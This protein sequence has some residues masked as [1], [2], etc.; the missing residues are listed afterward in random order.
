MPEVKF[1]PE[2]IAQKIV[3]TADIGE[4]AKREGCDVKAKYGR[5]H[6]TCPNCGGKQ[7]VTIYPPKNGKPANF[8]CHK[9]Q[10]FK[11]VGAAK[12]LMLAKGLTYPEALHDLAAHYNIDIETET[13]D[14]VYKNAPKNPFRDKQ[15]LASGIPLEVQKWQHQVKETTW[16]ERDRYEGGSLQKDQVVPGDDMILNYITLEGKPM[17]FKNKKGRMRPLVRVRWQHPHLHL[18]KAGKPM[19]YKSLY[20]SPSAVWLP[21][22]LIAAWIKSQQFD[23]LY[24]PEGEKKSEK[25]TIHGMYAAGLQGINNLNFGE[26]TTTFERIITRC[27]VKRI[28]FVVDSDWDNISSGENVDWRPKQF[29]TAAKK[30]KNYFYGYRNSFR[31]DG[32]SI[33]LD[34]YIA[35][36]LDKAEKG[37]DD[38]LSRSLK[39]REEELEQDY[40]KAFIDRE[41]VGKH[42]RVINITTI[43]EYKLQELWHL[44]S[45]AKFIEEHKDAL[46]D[47][48]QF[49]INGYAYHW[50]D[51]EAELMDQIHEDEQFWHEEPIVDRFGEPK[52]DGDGKEKFKLSFNYYACW[53]FLRNRG[54]YLFK[55][56]E[57]T[58]G[59]KYR[60]IRTQGKVVTETDPHEIQQFV[61]NYVEQLGRIDVL[62]MLFRGG[63]QYLGPDKLGNLWYS[64]PDFIKPDPD[65]TY[66]V[67]KNNYWKI[68][69][70]K[71][72]QRPLNEMSRYVW[73]RS[74]IDF[75]PKLINDFLSVEREGEDWKVTE[76]EAAKQCEMY[77]FYLCTSDFFWRKKYEL[78][79]DDEGVKFWAEKENPEKY[80][81]EEIAEM[82][83]HMVCKMIA[84]GYTLQGYRKKSM[85][86]A[87]VAMD[88][89]ETAVGKSE[90]GTGKSI[91]GTQFG[92]RAGKI[93]PT[94][95][96]D[97]KKDI[98]RDP[99]PFDGLDERHKAIVFDDVR[100]NFKFEW[101]FSK[102]TTGIEANWKNRQKLFLDPVPIWIITNHAIR[103]NSNSYLRRQYMLAFSDFFNGL[104]SPYDVFGHQLF[105]DW[106]WEEWNRYYNFIACC[107]QTYLRFNN[108]NRYVI[109]DQ[110]LE[111]RKLRQEIGENFLEFA[112]L[113][114]D[115]PDDTSASQVF[116]PEALQAHQG[117]YRNVAV[118][119]KKVYKDF[120]TECPQEQRFTSV[121]KVK[122]KVKLYCEYAGL[123]F[124]PGAD[125][126]G[127]I[128]SGN[129][130]YL[131]VADE[132]FN[133]EEMMR[134]S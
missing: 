82:T 66:L 7:K 100:V 112:E 114:F 71:I 37:I 3:D 103:G 8:K 107:I 74:I 26:M 113:Y 63:S 57:N 91:L 25:M 125:G 54:Y 56:K 121:M 111:K 84:T 35:F 129:L 12:F 5:D 55:I 62:N 34:I 60:L 118:E 80:T 83:G 20:G 50:V 75:E 109:P 79:T 46:K 40:Q 31:E 17:M 110:D 99:F 48:K 27:G 22:L 94:F 73:E 45:P 19:K 106:G 1:I 16:M 68:T 116:G 85:M 9:C 29:F 24:I 21:Q 119:K 39:G 11:G 90:G 59:N 117:P 122:Y 70:D 61:K 38:V 105:D 4:I 53:Q 127:R 97:G 72:E 96:I 44:Q 13:V 77:L 87:I 98:D 130:E 131:L 78:A 124:N 64:N 52:L 42:V 133:K 81:K 86:K 65:A 32:S 115:A 67:F 126:K 15:L 92:M 104:R 43:S 93:A 102:I 58:E 30:F 88:G 47:R 132:N 134:V 14:R 2:E 18:S 95:V 23:T 89:M 108:L 28:V 123:D 120:I 128:R 49:K 36:G 41:G 33:E 51:G 69:A 10:E 6:C 101:L 76:S